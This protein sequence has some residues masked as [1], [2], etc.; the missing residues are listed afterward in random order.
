MIESKEEGGLGL[1]TA[2]GRN[3][4]LLTK[5]NWR[6]HTK[7]EA[8]WAKVLRLKYY[9]NKG[10]NAINANML[11]CSQIWAGV[12]KGREV[13]NKGSMWMVGRHNNINFLCGNWTNKVIRTSID[14]L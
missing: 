2:K 4:A 13:L 9:S 14:T 10:T 3:I 1:Q 11:L 5:L 7:K 6:F 8:P 12:K